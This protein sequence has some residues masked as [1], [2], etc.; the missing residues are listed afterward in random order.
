MTRSERITLLFY[1][2]FTN[3]CKCIILLY[4]NANAQ[5]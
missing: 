5:Q 4:Y 1:I 2:L 3:S